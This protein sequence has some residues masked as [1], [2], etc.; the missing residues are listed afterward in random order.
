MLGAIKHGLH[1]LTSAIAS[2][3]GA[4]TFSQR[5]PVVV[6]TTEVTPGAVQV[7]EV[8][9]TMFPGAAGTIAVGG[10]ASTDDGGYQ[11]VVSA[12]FA[13]LGTGVA[14]TAD[15]L[16][17]DGEIINRV[18]IYD[19]ATGEP[20]ETPLGEQ[21][22]GLLQAQAAVVDGDAIAAAG[23]ENLQITF[24]YLPRANPALNNMQLF[25]MTAA[26]LYRLGFRSHRLFYNAPYSAL[27]VGGDPI[28]DVITSVYYIPTF[29]GVVP[30]DYPAGSMLVA[31]D[32]QEVRAAQ[33]ASW[34]YLR[35]VYVALAGAAADTTITDDD[36]IE[37]VE[38]TTGA[39]DRTLVLPTAADNTTRKITFIKADAG[40]GRVIIDGEGGEL[41]NAGLTQVIAAQYNTLTVQC[42][43]TGWFIV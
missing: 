18:D 30:G 23:V 15:Y 14:S 43:G 36:G 32:T 35:G 20:V 29:A 4:K 28:P 41:I 24:V 8:D 40:V 7:I 11:A 6:G 27:I 1:T 38:V 5:V 3:L 33:A 31:A 37:V 2:A 13:V 25:T 39:A 26:T 9:A 17:G 22:F 42:N 19:S 16:V 12:G 21:V 34:L 10:P